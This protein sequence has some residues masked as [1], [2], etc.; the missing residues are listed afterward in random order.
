[1]SV[2]SNKKVIDIAVDLHRKT[3]CV[4]GRSRSLSNHRS[5]I[6][7][8][9]LVEAA[10]KQR[11]LTAARLL[12]QLRGAIPDDSP[13]RTGMRRMVSDAQ[14][15]LAAFAALGA[16]RL[17]FAA[18]CKTVG[19]WRLDT[20]ASEGW[21]VTGATRTQAMGTNQA[22]TTGP[23]MS[24][25]REPT[26]M[27]G[28]VQTIMNADDL[29]RMGHF[30][31]AH[32][33]LVEK[34]DVAAV[35]ISGLGANAQAGCTAECMALIGLRMARFA[36][37]SGST[38][39]ARDALAQT[40][41]WIQQ[42]PPALHHYLLAEHAV[43]GARNQYQAEPMEFSAGFQ[44]AVIS[45]LV[46]STEAP[47]LQAE[48]LQLQGLVARRKMH[49]MSKSAPSAKMYVVAQRAVQLHESAIYWAITS[50]DAYATQSMVLNYAYL[51]QR[52]VKSGLHESFAPALQAYR[53]A[54]NIAERF[55]FADECGWDYIMPGELWVQE[56]QVREL[57]ASDSLLWPGGR[58]PAQAS[59]YKHLVQVAEKI[60]DARQIAEA[61]ELQAAFMRLTGHS[62]NK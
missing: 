52:I 41:R 22:A 12:V 15:A 14:N 34:F 23:L 26:A 3:L 46:Q 57:M 25:S 42:C 51:L 50:R 32:S 6:F 29:A 55:E 5:A 20:H 45:R 38:Q 48:W 62:D 24:V 19:P 7:L 8:A 54:M 2:V 61:R 31:D 58:N 40:L 28:I 56:Q 16:G 59:Y 4:N 60:G 35:N 47:Q 9:A 49:A 11:A 30:A 39:G 53:V 44:P 21:R 18:R 1:M 10:R 33:Y 43:S 27:L 37:I 13:D 36:R 17:V